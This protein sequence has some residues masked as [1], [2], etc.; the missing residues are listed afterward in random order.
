MSTDQNH[1]VIEIRPSHVE[2]GSRV[3]EVERKAPRK[4]G[5]RLQ[6]ILFL[7]TIVTTLIAGVSF[8]AAPTELFH[9][10]SLIL[11][12]I[13]FS[14]SL[15]SILMAHEMGHYVT[16]RLHKVQVTLPYF[17]PAP[18]LIGTLGAVIK[19][20][21]RLGK[22]HV[23]MEIGAAGPFAGIVVAVPLVLWGLGHSQIIPM[24]V[25]AGEYIVFGDSLLFMFLTKITVGVIPEGYDLLLHPVGFAGWVGFLVTSLNLMPIGQLDGGHISYA[26][27]GKRHRIV[28]RLFVI[29]LVVLGAIAYPGW[30]MWA[31][32]VLIIGLDHPPVADD[33]APLG[34][35]H[36]IIGYAALVL[37]VLTFIPQPVI[38][39]F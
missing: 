16:A 39:D 11:L 36:L 38:L 28:S 30:L 12:G 34:M 32:L 19:M 35:L 5:W 21:S 6:L 1:R 23:L 13:P 15:L 24:D 14:A 33:A 26:L 3:R 18:T 20:R 9:D 10:P 27:F 4:N 29:F 7:L 2:Y 17:I 31:L 25:G 37:L 22:K 8:Y